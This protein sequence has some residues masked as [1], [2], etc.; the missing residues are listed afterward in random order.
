M[1]AKRYFVGQTSHVEYTLGKKKTLHTGGLFALQPLSDSKQQTL[2]DAPKPCRVVITLSEK[3]LGPHSLDIAI[4]IKQL[5]FVLYDQWKA[6]YHFPERTSEAAEFRKKLQEN[7]KQL[8]L[9][10]FHA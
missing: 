9:P 7:F 5:A 6:N 10:K 8:N 2:E 1:R 4:Y 3:E